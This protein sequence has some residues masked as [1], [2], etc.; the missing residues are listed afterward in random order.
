M[1]DPADAGRRLLRSSAV[2]AAG[3]TASRVT[4]LLRTVAQA[5]ALGGA[6][7]GLADSYN[8][9]NT[10]PNLLFDL[11]AGG[12]LAATI[13][14]AL[15][16][17]RRRR[18]RAATSAAISVLGLV[19]LG[20]SAVAMLAAPV[21]AWAFAGNPTER[22]L[23]LS[24]LL[25]FLPQ[26]FFYGLT[27]LLAG[28]LN[29]HRRFAAAAFAP[30]VNNVVAV[31]I[32]VLFHLR[33]GGNPT[34]ASVSSDTASTLLLGLG[35]T[36]GIVVMAL[37]LVPATTRLR[38][39][40]QFSP[41]FHHPI[42]H[43]VLRLSAWTFGYVATNQVAFW[44]VFWLAKRH[45]DGEL[46]RYQYA[47]QFFQLPY[48]ILAASVIT[49]FLPDLADLV[50]SGDRA[51]F[52]ARFM[53][54]LRATLLLVLPATVGYL[55]VSHASVSVLLEHGSFGAADAAATGDILAAFAI[56]LPGFCLFMLAMRGFYAHDNTKMPFLIN[57]GQTFVFLGLC[58]L[59]VD[60]NGAAGLAL[61]FAVSY[62]VGAA[63]ALV[64]LDRYAGGLAWQASATTIAKSG[65]AALAMAVAVA[66][67]DAWIGADH[68]GGAWLRTIVGAVVGLAV[69]AGAA[70]ALRI[71][72]VHEVRRLLQRS[73]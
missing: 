7:K 19:L 49:A 6:S 11:L 30:V 23:T 37:I 50:R 46:S 33:A 60:S 13:V 1:A 9:A 51:G 5:A 29:A 24:F 25:C 62:C 17:A 35:T 39:G 63:A 20:L 47:Y 52:D 58:L 68:G 64:W 16:D 48:G 69:Y 45:G 66:P 32:L 41:D 70:I 72:E 27:A 53:L 67:I 2:V 28:L 34:A 8:I 36:A 4:G 38:L 10:A 55:L 26:I 42:V 44:I 54:G 65:L 12:V 73:A 56:G 57:L 21:I 61:S 40:L 22:E 18:D 3:T 71:P 15:S 31:A 59:T 43:K 14:P